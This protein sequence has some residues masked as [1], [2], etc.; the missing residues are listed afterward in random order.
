MVP[1][2]QR[3]NLYLHVG[4]KLTLFSCMPILHHLKVENRIIRKINNGFRL[5]LFTILLILFLNCKS[6]IIYLKYSC[7]SFKKPKKLMSGP[8]G[9]QTKVKVNHFRSNVQGF[10]RKYIFLLGQCI[11]RHIVE[12]TYFLEIRKFFI[13][14]SLKIQTKYL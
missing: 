13:L 2:E 10:A 5:N 4:L 9:G 11:V 1:T 6:C 14:S 3:I 8:L 12:T 7:S